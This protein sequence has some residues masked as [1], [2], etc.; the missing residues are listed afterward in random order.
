MSNNSV[1]ILPKSVLFPMVLPGLLKRIASFAGLGVQCLK[2]QTLEIARK[3][4]HF[5][6]VSTQ[7]TWSIL[8][9]IG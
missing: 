2:M 6:Q 8:V 1:K 4:E 3:E 7:T 5:G 9:K